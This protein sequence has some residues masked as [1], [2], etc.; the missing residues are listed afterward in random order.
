MEKK[1]FTILVADD[2]EIA[3]DVVGSILSREGYPVVLAR[4]GHEAM[5]ALQDGSSGM[6]ITDLRMPGPDGLM[7]LKHAVRISPDI[8][9]V[10]LTAYGTLD[11]TLEAMQEGAYDYLT[12]PFKGQEIIILADRAFKRAILMHEN[13]ELRLHLRNIC[14]ELGKSGGISGGVSARARTAWLERLER[15]ESLAVLSHEEA[16]RAKERLGLY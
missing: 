5:Q 13:N 7:V 2:D 4:D 15:L 11:T 8:A 9:V 1:D 16:Q 6:V 3:R 12:K 10:V 14:G